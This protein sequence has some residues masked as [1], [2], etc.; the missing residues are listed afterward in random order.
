MGVAC[1][2][3][4]SRVTQSSFPVPEATVISTGNENQ[5]ARRGN[6]SSQARH[7][8][9]G[10]ALRF[11][12]IYNAERDLPG[13]LPGIQIHGIQSPPRWLLA[14]VMVL[15]PK[16]RIRS[17][18]AAPHICLGRARRLRFHG[19]YRAYFVRIHKEI[20]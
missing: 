14:W 10:N 3:A 17:P 6:R 20:A 5:P 9:P 2:L 18:L 8:R 1:P 16:T 4:S 7:A 15:I 13:N 11:Q 19:T 12:F